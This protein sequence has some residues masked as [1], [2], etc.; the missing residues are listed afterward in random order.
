[1]TKRVPLILIRNCGG[2]WCCSS[3]HVSV[4]TTVSTLV[5]RRLNVCVSPD[6]AFLRMFLAFDARVSP[7]Q[8]VT[9]KVC[10]AKI[11]KPCCLAAHRSAR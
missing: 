8:S 4:S 7:G 6:L 2:L 10:G 1:M 11:A 3:R 9:A 5:C